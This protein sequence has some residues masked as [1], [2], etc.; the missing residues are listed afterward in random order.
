M[1]VIAWRGP[2]SLGA[3]KMETGMELNLCVKLQTAKIQVPPKMEQRMAVC[4]SIHTM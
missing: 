2:E 4:I 1:M 3:M